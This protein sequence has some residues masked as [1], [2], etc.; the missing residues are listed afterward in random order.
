MQ[1]SGRAENV[2][3][4]M[5]LTHKRRFCDSV[6][7]GLTTEVSIQTATCCY[8]FMGYLYS[9]AVQ[10]YSVPVCLCAIVYGGRDAPVKLQ[11][12]I[13][14]LMYRHWMKP[15]RNSASC[16]AFIKGRSE[17]EGLKLSHPAPVSATH[18]RECEHMYPAC[19]HCAVFLWRV[20]DFKGFRA[21]S[22]HASPFTRYGSSISDYPNILWY[23]NTY[24]C[25]VMALINNCQRAESSFPA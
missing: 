20:N 19:S 5:M 3:S 2:Q 15:L 23:C 25:D 13:G 6:K 1:A 17:T 4:L 22:C 11:K 24:M 16:S 21:T 7:E 12:H 10:H 8:A 18:S 9:V 14:S